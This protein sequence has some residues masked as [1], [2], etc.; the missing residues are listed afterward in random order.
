MNEKNNQFLNDLKQEIIV[1]SYKKIEVNY[2]EEEKNK[3]FF[4]LKDQINALHSNPLNK[5]DVVNL[6]RYAQFYSYWLD[7]KKSTISINGVKFNIYSVNE[8]L[9]FRSTVT[10]EIIEAK[11]EFDIARILNKSKLATNI[12]GNLF[13]NR[14]VK[15]KSRKK[16]LI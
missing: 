12:L 5:K 1:K 9:Y 6:K 16:T 14:E 4:S 8:E 15:E 2:K 13:K 10:N 7:L 11:R 3:Y